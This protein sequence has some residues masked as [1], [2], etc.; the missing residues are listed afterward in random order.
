ME[1]NLICYDILTLILYHSCDTR[2]CFTFH[3]SATLLSLVCKR[4]MEI[5]KGNLFKILSIQGTG[6]FPLGKHPLSIKKDCRYHFVWRDYI[7][8]YKFKDASN[9]LHLYISC[10]SR[11]ELHEFCVIPSIDNLGEYL[12]INTQSELIVYHKLINHD[13]V[14]FRA[15]ISIFSKNTVGF[16]LKQ[17]I[18]TKVGLLVFGYFI[19]NPATYLVTKVEFHTSKI[20]QKF[21]NLSIR[22]CGFLGIYYEDANHLMLTKWE[23]LFSLESAGPD[24]WKEMGE[25]IRDGNF[26]L[27]LPCIGMDLVISSSSIFAIG[28]GEIILWSLPLPFSDEEYILMRFGEIAFI[29]CDEKFRALMDPWSGKII[30]Y[31]ELFFPDNIVGISAN[32]DASGYTLHLS[33]W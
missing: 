24:S 26:E 31:D 19:I 17:I 10:D 12:A 32:I 2:S 25:K 13:N 18:Y 9:F 5:I 33:S 22:Q 21:L 7:G 14:V 8:K 1:L 6:F 29:C 15:D 23:K 20:R 30:C 3:E 28:I 27:L 11:N 16:I 4:W